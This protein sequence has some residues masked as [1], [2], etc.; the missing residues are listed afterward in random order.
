VARVP[1]LQPGAFYRFLRF[2]A[3]PLCGIPAQRPFLLR[4]G[5]LYMKSLFVFPLAVLAFAAGPADTLAGLSAR[6]DWAGIAGYTAAHPAAAASVEGRYLRSHAALAANDGNRAACGFA[7]APAP[8]EWRKWAEALL[9]ANSASVTAHYL[10]GDAFAR[11]GDLAR[12]AR[13][14]DNALA[15][16]PHDALALHA[17][18]VVKTLLG[19]QDSALIDFVSASG[20]NHALAAAHVSRR[21]L[22]VSRKGSAVS[23]LKSFDAALLL[24]PRSY[25]A[26]LGRAACRRKHRSKGRS[27]PGIR[28]QTHE[29]IRPTGGPSIP[30]WRGSTA[31]TKWWRWRGAS[32]VSRVRLRIIGS[33]NTARG[34]DS[35]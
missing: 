22:Y 19:E 32:R 13:E 18:G 16:E 25:M 24:D 26:L 35:R 7:D 23:E 4:K 8:D 5:E 3:A 27:R 30:S 2:F 1:A 10:A 33:R 14:F 9:A 20:A 11:T 28:R 34:R 6:G 31:S 21:Y 17:R 12:A 15:I 29:F